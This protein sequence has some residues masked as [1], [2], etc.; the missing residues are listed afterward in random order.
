MKA[1]AVRIRH[2]RIIVAAGAAIAALAILLLSRNFNFYFDEWDFIVAAPDWTWLSFLQP[3]NEHPVVIPKLIYAALLNT[4]GLHA[5]WPYMAVLLAL[6]ATNAFLLFELVR[7]RSGDLIGVAAAALMLVL[8]AG[9]ENLLWAFQMTFVGSVTCGLGALLALQRLSGQRGIAAVVALTTA[10]I[11]FSG[12]GLF[13]AVAVAAQMAIDKARRRDLVWLAPIAVALVIWYVTLGRTG[14]PTNPPP[15][16][17]NLTIAPVY[18]LWG[19]GAA[20]AALIGEGGWWSAVAL[21]PALAAVGWSWWRRTPDAFALAIATA[22]LSL[23]AVTALTRGQFGYD[24][25]ASGRYVYEGAI[26]WLLLLSDAAAALPWRGTWRPVLAA[27]VFLACFNS[28][29][30]LF[31]Y[32]TAKTVQMQREGADLQALNSL[33]GDPCLKPSGYA[34]ALV[35]PQVNSPALYYRAVDKYGDPAPKG[36]VTDRTDY[37]RAR[38]SLVFTSCR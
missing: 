21:V 5:Y 29:A 38:Q 31:E 27:C 13:F 17:L 30:L 33:R 1:G 7:R 28:A 20:V 6:H 16:V 23:Y 10:S 36:P 8:G 11:L 12:I 3:H 34:D 2:A 18:V 4:F 26:F 37:D 25:A 24:Q 35:M 19:L 15:S 32:G 22:M 9:W 14:T